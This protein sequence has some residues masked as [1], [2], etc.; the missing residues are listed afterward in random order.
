M[1]LSE[2]FTLEEATRSTKAIQLGIDNSL[3]LPLL[4]DAIMFT[5]NVLQP[6]RDEIKLPFLITS[7]Y[8]S[9]AL[10]KAVKGAINSAHLSAM[11]VDLT[12]KGMTVTE[13]YKTILAA[14]EKLKIPYDQLISEHNKKTGANWVH[15]G[16]KKT[17]NR[18]Q[19]FNLQV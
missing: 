16:C 5:T 14:L 10:N 7:W 19:H 18:F 11:A 8:R 15:L 17:N 6:L 4:K 3:S 12:I 9:P 13:S 2:N 1:K